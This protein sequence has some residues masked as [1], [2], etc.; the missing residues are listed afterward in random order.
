MTVEEKTVD[1]EKEAGMSLDDKL[2]VTKFNVDDRSHLVIIDQEV[3]RRC[4]DRPCTHF[5]P[6]AVYEW[7]D[8]KIIVGFEG[9]LECGSCRIACPHQ[10]IE[11]CYPRGG[12]GVS[13]RFG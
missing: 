10:N 11:W 7:E 6:A 1:E 3:C 2:Y 12:F 4:E 8:G 5:C 13:Y 9:C